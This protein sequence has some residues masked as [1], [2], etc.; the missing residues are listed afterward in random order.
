[1]EQEGRVV[2]KE[3]Q[4]QPKG[5][6]AKTVR[7]IHS[8]LYSAFESAIRAGII[9]QN[10]AKYCTLP[11]KEHKQMIRPVLKPTKKEKKMI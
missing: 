10:P 3:S 4:N 6:S 7:N 2:R 11:K 9:N 5:L 8:I 1:L